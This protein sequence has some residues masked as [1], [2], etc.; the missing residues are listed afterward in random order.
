MEH[1]SEGKRVPWSQIVKFAEIYET[2]IQP[3]LKLQKNSQMTIPDVEAKTPAPF[4]KLHGL[5]TI[6]LKDINLLPNEE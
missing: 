1:Q 3:A 6:I 2:E 4:I 5:L